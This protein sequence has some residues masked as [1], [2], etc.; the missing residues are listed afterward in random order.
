MG[1]SLIAFLLLKD[2]VDTTDK[3][4]VIVDRSGQVADTL[5]ETAR[6]R[7]ETELLDDETGDKVRPA[8][9]FREEQYN[10]AD[11]TAQRL[12]LSDRVRQGELHAF[13]EIGP[14]VVHPIDRGDDGRILY[15]AKN[16]A[17]DDLRRWV[18]G[19]I[20]SQLRRLRMADA[21]IDERE[22]ADLFYWVGV[23][24]LGLVTMD[25]ETGDVTEAKRASE[26]EALLIPIVIMMLMFLMMMMSVPGMLHSVMEEKTQRIAE[27]LLSSM[28]PFE[29]MMG[30]VLGG[31]A[32]AF[33]SAAVYFVGGILVVRYMGYNEYIPYR[34]LTWFFAY[35][36]LAVVMF[37]AMSA[38]LGATCSEPKDAQSL[39]FP[40][41]LPILIPM[42][43]YFPIAREPAG[44]FATWMSLIPLFTPTLMTLRIATPETIPP[45]Q[46][47]VG[48]AAVLAST[49]L[50]VWAGGRIFRIAILIQGTPP[51]LSNIIRWAARG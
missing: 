18:G 45:W 48:L 23:E 25:T 34:A 30:K 32:V 47:L 16:A 8:Y 20:N 11:P 46:P 9:L 50:F 38:A 49:F 12:E 10:Q 40:T 22:A 28:K 37:G 4:V 51:K 27:V 1:G 21:G 13:I 35:L 15:Y 2:R 29:F 42:F 41:I 14:E 39:T 43:I 44:S 6:A 26:I 17:L 19:P 36:P 31:I 5:L 24:G 33:T 3:E 7:N